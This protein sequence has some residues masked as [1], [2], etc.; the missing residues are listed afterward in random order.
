MR[1]W[2]RYSDLYMTASGCTGINAI[3]ISSSHDAATS[4]AIINCRS[5]SKTLG[6]SISI[7][8]G[9]SDDHDV[10][11]TGYVK[12][13][14]RKV[15]DNTYTISAGDVMVRA[16]DYFIVSSNPEQPF[17]R[18][19]IQA[20]TLVRD[21]LRLAGLTNYDHDDTNFTFAVSAPAEINLV[22]AYDYCK[23]IAD[24]LTW[25]LWADQDGQVNFKNRKPYPIEAGDPELSQP[26]VH[27]DTSIGTIAE[28]TIV[29][30]QYKLTEKDLRNRIVVYG[31][32]GIFAEKKAASAEGALPSGFYKTAV[33]ASPI[34]DDRSMATKSASYNLTLLN[35]VQ[36]ELSMTV[37]GDKLLVPRNVITIPASIEGTAKKYYI[38]SADH[39]ITPNGYITNMVLMR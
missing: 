34:I 5:T 32:Q 28:D 1:S 33:L 3:T 38:Y 11:F 23:S 24:L 35:R 14:D 20:E 13:I 29:S 15:P 9:Y 4:N 30:Y 16:V 37:L 39:S 26:G 22:S 18:Q 2:T 27:V 10:L 31:A 21:I 8:I 25:G 17:T 6:D 19:N 12:T 7:N 36:R